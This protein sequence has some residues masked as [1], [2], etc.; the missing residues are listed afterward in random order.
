M[1]PP[2]WLSVDRPNHIHHCTSE[3]LR[4]TAKSGPGDNIPLHSTP[5]SSSILSA[6]FLQCVLNFSWGS[7][8]V[9]YMV[10]HSPVTHSQ[11]FYESGAFV[12]T[13]TH[14]KIKLLWPKLPTVIIYRDKH[15]YLEGN[16]IGTSCFWFFF[17]SKT[18]NKWKQL[19]FHTRV[20]D[21]LSHWLLTGFNCTGHES[22]LKSEP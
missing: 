8:D 15:K 16:L 5:P 3:F 13:A 22:L 11:H 7:V 12:I 17:F 4:A 1:P 2:P 9:L 21:L 10:E 18:N 6:S 14:C 19:Y 20:Y